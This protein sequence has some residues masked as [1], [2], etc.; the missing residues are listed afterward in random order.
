M[1]DRPRTDEGPLFGAAAALMLYGLVVVLASVLLGKELVP[2]SSPLIGV[3]MVG[4]LIA[5]AVIGTVADTVAR[6]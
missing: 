5:G 2:S 1:A 3:L 6:R 4:V